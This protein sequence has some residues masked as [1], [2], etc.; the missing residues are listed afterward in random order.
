MTFSHVRHVL[1]YSNVIVHI[2]II[3]HLHR[4]HVFHKITDEKLMIICNISVIFT[5]EGLQVAESRVA[6]YDGHKQNITRYTIHSTEKNA[7]SLL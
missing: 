1:N 6:K 2:I 5:Q 4:S 3:M 7:G